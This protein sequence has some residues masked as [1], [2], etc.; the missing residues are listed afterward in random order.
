MSDDMKKYKLG[1]LVDVISGVTYSP[2]D[3]S[4]NG[5]RILRGG[6]IQSNG[7]EIK[8]NDVFLP[9]SYKNTSNQIRIGDTILVAS[10]GSDKVLGKAA[11]CFKEIPN[12]Q[13]GAFLRIIR[14]KQ[15]KYAMLVSIALMSS[16][17]TKYITSQVKGTNINNINTN[18]LKMFEIAFPSEE[19]L[20]NISSLYYVI[21]QKIEINKAINHNLLTPDHSSIGVEVRLVA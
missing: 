5:I 9:A 14:A 20:E 15:P 2:N 11:T 17:F 10:T 19:S 18:H 16:S 8:S 4:P 12:T 6:N 1:E 7:I 3:L 21:Q 13:I